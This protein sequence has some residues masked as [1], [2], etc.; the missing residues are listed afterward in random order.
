MHHP[1]W[2]WALLAALLLFLAGTACWTCVA[3]QSK[4][5]LPK[6]Q[7][8]DELAAPTPI[9]KPQLALLPLP[10]PTL[11]RKPKPKKPKQ[12]K[13]KAKAEQLK[14]KPAPKKPRKWRTVATGHY[15]G[16]TGPMAVQ[17]GKFGEAK[18]GERVVIGEED[19]SASESEPDSS[20]D[21]SDLSSSDDESQHGGSSGD[22]LDLPPLPALEIEMPEEEAKAV[23]LAKKRRC[24]PHCC[25]LLLAL[26][27]AEVLATVVG[28][29]LRY[30]AA[31]EWEGQG[32]H[33]QDHTDA[34]GGHLAL[35]H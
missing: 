20:S 17:W 24:H 21:E 7:Y 27:I 31:E 19:S 2:L 4:H 8:V 35:R 10:A 3:R 34:G 23:D 11:P 28:L 9:E 14:K 18:T 15:I 6:M 29:V 25:T 13:K 5:K 33:Q 12:K 26:A 30:T 1:Y 32:H 16:A 22:E